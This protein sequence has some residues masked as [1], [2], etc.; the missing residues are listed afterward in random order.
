MNAKKKE[1]E[2][3]EKE[4]EGERLRRAAQTAGLKSG[5]KQA[6]LLFLLG[7]EQRIELILVR[8]ILEHAG[9][10]DKSGSEVEQAERQRGRR[11]ER[12]ER[13]RKFT[14]DRPATWAAAHL[15]T[16]QATARVLCAHFVSDS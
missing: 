8:V 7:S 6:A 4:R 9:E 12:G 13:L 2:R 14:T 10:R 3:R 15:Q 5:H 16:V 1:K 11:E